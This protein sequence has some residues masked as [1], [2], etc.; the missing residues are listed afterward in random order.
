VRWLGVDTP[1]C[2]FSSGIGGNAA[3][4]ADEIKKLKLVVETAHEVWGTA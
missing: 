2:S 1:R 3:M 4:I